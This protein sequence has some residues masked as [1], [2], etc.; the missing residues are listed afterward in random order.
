MV[1]V[2]PDSS[3]GVTLLARVRAAR[4]S[5]LL[6]QAGEVE[7][8]RVLD[9]GHQEALLGV[10]REPDVLA[11]GVGDGAGLRVDGGVDDREL[12][13]RLDGGHRDERKVGQRCAL[14]LLEIVL[15]L[16]P[17][18]ADGRDVH[19][20]GGGELGRDLERLHHPR[21]DRLAQPRQLLRGAAHLSGGRR[22]LRSGGCRS[23]CLRGLSRSGGGLRRLGRGLGCL[24]R[25]DHVL[26]ADASTDAGALDAGQLHAVFLRELAHQRRDVGAVC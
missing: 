24:S 16:G 4:S 6:R 21:R 7:V 8:S 13:E 5:D 20:D 18:V 19:L 2:P 23:S 1:N 17:D 11:V 15:D 3:S 12:L 9:D 25:L 26:L 14:A 22:G 10:H